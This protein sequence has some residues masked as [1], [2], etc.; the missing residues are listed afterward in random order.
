[1]RVFDVLFGPGYL[2]VLVAP[3]GV[4]RLNEVVHD[5]FEAFE[6]AFQGLGIHCVAHRLVPGQGFGSGSRAAGGRSAGDADGILARAG[7]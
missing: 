3:H 7:G 6:V 4:D 2:D 5:I 1:M